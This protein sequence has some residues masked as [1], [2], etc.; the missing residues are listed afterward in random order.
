[1]PKY[2]FRKE[3]SNNGEQ[4]E[5]LQNEIKERDHLIKSVIDSQKKLKD[6]LEDTQRKIENLS[7]ASIGMPSI[8]NPIDDDGAVYIPKADLKGKADLAVNSEI[9]E[10]NKDEVRKL[11]K[12][13]I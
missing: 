5:S 9:S 1:M 2:F 4:F 12:K 11:K 7:V 10:S 13:K 8:D 6:A 3:K